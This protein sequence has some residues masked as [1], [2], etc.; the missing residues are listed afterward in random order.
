MLVNEG[1]DAVDRT[2][3]KVLCRNSESDDQRFDH[4]TTDELRVDKLPFQSILSSS[5]LVWVLTKLPLCSSF[6]VDSLS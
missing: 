4:M 3:P 6:K 5:L 1:L 2:A